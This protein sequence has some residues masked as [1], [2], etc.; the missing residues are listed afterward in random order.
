MARRRVGPVGARRLADSA[1]LADAVHVLARSPYGPQVGPED[2][3][4][5]A[6]YGVA[7]ATLW[8]LRVLAGWLPADGAETLRLL[9]GWFEIANVDQH[10]RLLTTPVGGDPVWSPPLPLPPPFR[11]GSLATAWPRLAQ[12]G[13]VSELRTTL[14]TSAWKDPGEETPRAIALWLR[15]SWATRVSAGVVPARPWAAG[16]V[17]LLVARELAVTRQRLPSAVMDAACQLLGTGW[18][19]AT[20]VTELA[21]AMPSAARWALRGVRDAA[22]LWRA[23]VRW[24]SRLHQDALGLLAGSG[25]GPSRPVGAVAALGADAWRV[26]AAL[27]IAARGGAGR[28]VLDVL[29]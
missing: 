21:E 29:A 24:W 15:L 9:A 8:N 20:T 12:A 1:G 4:A 5:Q 3:L 10:L 23:E 2:G 16:A 28:E 22:D 14:S 26:S 7:A 6:Q 11:L 25:F 27:E 13:S 19:D 18:R 17:A